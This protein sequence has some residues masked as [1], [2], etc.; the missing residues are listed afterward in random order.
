VTVRPSSVL[1]ACNYNKVRSPMAASL[2]R[3]RYGEA[4]QV[5]C[6]GLR[7]ADAVDPFAVAVIDELGLDLTDYQP[8]AFADLDGRAYDLVISLT[9]E[10]H[11]RAVEMA[12][13]DGV[14]IEYWP[15]PDPTLVEGSREQRLTAYREA[16]DGLEARI[17]ARFGRPTGF[18]G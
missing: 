2:V 7:A 6:C 17:V 18:G 5:D 10:A 3:L 11:H 16:R 15:T 12:R 9:P 8:K 13:G 4:V 1:F 14:D